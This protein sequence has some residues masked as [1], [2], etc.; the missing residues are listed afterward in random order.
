MTVVQD[1]KDRLDIVE[2]VSEYAPLHKAGRNLKAN[3]PFHTEK[4]PSFIVFPDRQSWRCFGACATGGDVLSFF[5]KANGIDFGETISILAQR[6]GITL[7]SSHA[8]QT[9]TD[10]HSLILDA[11]N[12]FITT[13]E[14]ANGN[15]ARTYIK[16]RGINADALEMFQL[17]LSP[18]NWRGLTEHLVKIGHSEEDIISAGLSVRNDTGDIRDLFHN[19]LMFPIS[20]SSGHIVGFGGRTLNDS[21]PK[22]LNT[23][24]TALFDKSS[25]LYGLS[26]AK[27]SIRNHDSV[28]VV[29]GYMD[30]IS[31]HQN[32]YQ[33]VVAS[34]GTA[35]TEQQVAAL[36]NQASTFVLA[37]DPDNAGKEATL[38]SLESSWKALQINVLRSRGRNGIAFSQQQSAKSIK[39]ATLPYDQD[40]D[41]LIRQNPDKWLEV[42]SKASDLLD[43]LFEVLPPRFDISHDTGKMQLVDTLAPFIRGEQNTFSRQRYIRNLA[44]LASLTGSDLEKHIW[45]TAGPQKRQYARNVARPTDVVKS[46]PYKPLEEYCLFLLLRYPYLKETGIPVDDAH[47]ESTENRDLIG[48]LT[49][50]ATID[51]LRDNLPP[52]LTEHIDTILAFDSPPLNVKESER[53]LKEVANRLKERH[54]KM[55][56]QAIMDQME[57]A[58]W[59]DLSNLEDSS[60][61]F[62][63]INHNL[64]I[65]F[66]DPN[67]RIV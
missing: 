65:V 38:R 16:D 44:T 47:F 19:R 23:P 28:V 48:R 6:L 10:L 64:K 1:I 2:I 55:R 22:Y 60:H 26:L 45:Q 18:S 31:A 34:M 54:L 32:G 46:T 14:S 30:V 13:L 63:E 3:C 21:T 36:R 51:E 4:T 29:E 5:M 39:I 37:L 11:T 15:I 67:N 57:D 27:E 25:L 9:Q 41:T 12:Y 40:P 59:K 24:R 8:N 35:L 42:I 52:M 62:E 43:Y 53:A 33:N 50:Y 66:S 49:M 7:P 61:K 17:G 58:D 56:S 20:D